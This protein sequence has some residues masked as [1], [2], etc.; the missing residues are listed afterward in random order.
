MLSKLLLY[1]VISVTPDGGIFCTCTHTLHSLKEGEVA[2]Y[3]PP[4]DTSMTTATNLDADLD[5]VQID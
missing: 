4:P 1:V 3:L 5:R 2:P